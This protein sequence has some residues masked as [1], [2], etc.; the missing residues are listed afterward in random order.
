MGAQRLAR[1]ARLV[2]PA[3]PAAEAAAVRGAQQAPRVAA[4]QPP[5]EAAGWDV[6]G[7]PQPAAEWA[8]LVRRR[9]AAAVQGVAAARRRAAERAEVAGRPRG[10]EAAAPAAAEARRLEAA[11]RDAAEPLRAARGAQAVQLSAGDLFSRLQEARPAPTLEGA[12]SA[13][14]REQSARARGCLRTAPP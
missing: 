12:R 7:V 3:P 1:A 5:V 6:P 2:P 10:A 14:R 9:E 8:A 4:A 13:H 11:E